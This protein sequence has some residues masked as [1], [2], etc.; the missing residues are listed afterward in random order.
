M[1]TVQ[2]SKCSSKLFQHRATLRSLRVQ[3]RL[4]KVDATGNLLAGRMEVKESGTGDKMGLRRLRA[5]LKHM[6]SSLLYIL[7]KRCVFESDCRDRWQA[8]PS[9]VKSG[10]QEEDEAKRFKMNTD[11]MLELQNLL[12]P[13]ESRVGSSW[14]SAS[15]QLCEG[16]SLLQFFISQERDGRPSMSSL[17]RLSG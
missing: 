10:T 2:G 4:P 14:G 13:A 12:M 16:T 8:K 3:G 15:C 5:L 1:V 17:S 11:Q 7:N 6:S 9:S